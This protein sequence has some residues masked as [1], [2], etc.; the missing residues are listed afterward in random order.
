MAIGGE[1][2]RSRRN[3]LVAAVAGA[4]AVAAEGLVRPTTAAAASTALMTEVD[5]PTIATTS[6]SAVGSITK[7]DGVAFVVS[8][9]GDATA[10]RGDGVDGVGISGTSDLGNGVFGRSNGGAGVYGFIGDPIN[11]GGGSRAGVCG[12]SALPGLPGVTGNGQIGVQGG[13]LI[14]VQGFGNVGVIGQA[15]GLGDPGLFGTGVYGYSGSSSMP[16]APT[17]V[18]VCARA[19]GAAVALRVDGRATF[20]RSG[21]VTITAGHSSRVVSFAGVTTASLVIATIQTHRSG[22]YVASAVPASGKFTIYLNKAVSA[23]TRVAFFILN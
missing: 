5:N 19:G 9:S 18:G 13:G 3:V 22:V 11:D 2:Q 23:S 4:A 14:G 8:V 17:N 20:S 16:A 10:V 15:E 21:R 1:S 6:V 12:E 7:A